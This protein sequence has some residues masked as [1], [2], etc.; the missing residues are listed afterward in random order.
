MITLLAHNKRQIARQ[1]LNVQIPSYQKEAELLQTDRIPRLYDSINDILSC[2]EIFL[3]YFQKEEL[4]GFISF[5]KWEGNLVDIH[6]LVVAQ[7]HFRKG[8]AKSLLSSLL[9][10]F[11]NSTFTVSTG[12]DNTP[13]RNLY[14]NTGFIQTRSTQVEPN[15]WIN[16]YKRTPKRELP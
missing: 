2:N 8:I 14:E 11:P 1:I 10:R 4:A 15:L 16:H 6:R 7:A 13:A 9:N 5:K 12:E 3:G